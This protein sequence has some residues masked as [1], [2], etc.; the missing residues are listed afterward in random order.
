MLNAAADNIIHNAYSKNVLVK[1]LKIRFAHSKL[2][3]KAL[4]IPVMIWLIVYF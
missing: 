1:M 4:N 3:G 2:M